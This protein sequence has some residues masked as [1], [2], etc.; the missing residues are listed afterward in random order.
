MKKPQDISSRGARTGVIF[1]LAL[2][3]ALCGGRYLPARAGGVD[4]RGGG[5]AEVS[6]AGARG[7]SPEGAAEESPGIE[8]TAGG[9]G[10]FPG[11]DSIAWAAGRAW[12]ES[13][14]GEVPGGEP[15]SDTVSGT[16]NTEGAVGDSGEPCA[17][18]Q[19][20]YAPGQGLGDEG[21]EGL[22]GPEKTGASGED[23]GGDAY[24][25]GQVIVKFRK[26]TAEQRALEFLR[27]CGVK[28]VLRE[29][30]ARAGGLS[31]GLAG[32]LAGNPEAEP[33]GAGKAE[34][35]AGGEGGKAENGAGEGAGGTVR[36]LALADGVS[37]E[38]GLRV[39]RFFP[40]VEY[41]EP[42]YLRKAVYTPN[43]TYFG[44]QWAYHNTGQTIGGQVGTPDADMD[45]VEGWDVERGFTNPPT[46]AV[47]DTGTDL[48]HPDLQ[49]KLWVNADETAGNGV[50][51]DGNG[52]VD[53]RYGYNWAGISHLYEN[54][55]AWRLGYDADR[56]A[57]AQSIKGTGAY[58]TSV[59]IKLR[60]TGSPAQP[61]TVSV[62]SS[63]NGADLASATI[64]PS[65]VSSLLKMEV[66]KTL[67]SA[68]RL[69]AGATYYLVF[70]TAQND[71]ANYYLLFMNYDDPADPNPWYDL[72]ADG[73]GWRW[74]ASSSSW[75]QGSGYDF[76][77]RT[78]ANPVPR[79]D[80]GH[81]THCAG[82][83]GA[84]TGNATGVAGTC[85]GARVMSLKA[86]D[87]VGSF[88]SS[89][90]IAALR[91]AADNGA[92][93]ISMSFGGTSSSSA[94][95]DAVNYAY[96][97]GAVLCAAAGNDGNTTVNYPA[98]YAHVIGVGATDNQDQVATFSNY[99]A[100]VDLSAPGV[101]I[102]STSPT[103][104]V[105]L[106]SYGMPAN[107][108]YMSGTSMASPM[109][110]GA[111]ALLRSRNPSLGS[112]AVQQ[113]LQ[114]GADDKGD[115]G[116]DDHYGWG[117]VNIYRSLSLV[118]PTPSLT[119]LSPSSGKVGAQVTLNG[120]GFG[121]ARGSSHVSFGTVQVAEGDYVSWS[122]TR[123]VCRVPP[124]AAGSVQ[125][126]VTTGGGTSNGLPFNVL[127]FV[128]TATA[129]GVG[130]SVSPPSQNVSYGGTATVNISPLAGYGIASI[131]DNGEAKPVA[132][133]YYV[134]NV[135]RDHA[136]TVTFAANTYTI[137]C[138][139]D[140]SGSGSV[141]GAGAYAHGSTVRLEASANAGWR[142]VEWREGG[143]VVS[144][145]AV[146]TFT[147]ERDRSLVARFAAVVVPAAAFYFAEGTCRP[148]YTPYLCVQNPN[149]TA[150]TVRITYMLGN[151]RTQVYSISVPANSRATV[152]VK[153]HLG[154]GEDEAHDFSCKVECVNGLQIVAERPLYFNRG[155]VS[156]GHDVVGATSPAA[157]FCFAE[158]TCRPGYTP[159]LCVQ[160][161]NGTAAT[162]RITYMLGNGRTQVYSI[163]VPANSRA[164]VPVKAHLGEGE[165]EAHDFSCKVECVNGLQIVAER[166]VYFNRGGVS[167]GH[168]VV[169]YSP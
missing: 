73:C 55:W 8:I 157:A 43:D 148:G 109:A 147:A 104:P 69:T 70:S 146:Y 32:T 19:D 156:G 41:A 106:T 85:P 33:A 117:R 74:L 29:I 78:N 119:S 160:N 113:A 56:R 125:V 22:E 114:D 79:D 96:G 140:P 95:Q 155:G 159:Y 17:P 94:E 54:N 99:N 58:L 131:T 36:L 30:G 35:A 46:V 126:T 150:A 161:P 97:K 27:Q 9:A 153:A 81:G 89:D 15:W 143:G 105:A 57:F 64:N 72:Y 47:I 25:L 23:G 98:G 4:P 75:E 124:M 135:D 127:P 144:T 65:E 132:N 122:D 45:A 128:V 145:S 91:Y 169:G 110:A 103:Y 59:G 101:Y 133:P 61:I 83:V 24:A 12:E 53:D 166:P 80:D 151:G 164:T 63:L 50:D 18:G 6:A 163:S 142:F 86:G 90:V 76:Y 152:P 112:D 121:A 92:G 68:V 158:G 118:G 26:G 60:K 44:N 3:L 130:G 115:A 11:V 34:P 167:G 168:D 2:F 13:P 123:V 77:F 14:G 31:E 49:N 7:G 136:V 120:S 62:R 71:T 100:S 20:P 39:L 87:C 165:D 141:T 37:V 84:E 16:A 21:L 93:V 42:D 138:A 129:S 111:A 82:I 149:G 40:W 162:V 66:T 10:S 107:Y 48:A 67:S 108:C 52:Y 5:R 1:L 38:E 51:D 116:R 134:H 102:A 139:V 154:E 28:E 137:A 88:Y